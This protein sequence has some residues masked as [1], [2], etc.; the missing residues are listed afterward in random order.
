M[1]IITV[2]F[3]IFFFTAK[4]FGQNDTII[5]A[6]D[7][8]YPPFSFIDKT[9]KPAGYDIE[10]ANEIA[11]I[12]GLKIKISLVNWD[13]ALINLE[14]GKVDVI[15][16]LAYSSS[17]QKKV[18]FSF[19]L[20]TEFYTIF[21]KKKS[22]I[23][24]PGDL[25]NKI[26]AI[27][28]NDI[29]IELFYEPM[30]LKN[31]G[32]IVKSMPE[33]FS[34]INSDSCD[35]AIVP[36][37]LGAQVIED[38]NLDN[39]ESKGE[40]F[41]PSVFC[42]A[43]K[44]DNYEVLAFLNQ[45]IAIMSRD[46]ELDRIYNKWV[47]Y[48]QKEDRY[49]IFFYYALIGLSIFAAIIVLLFLFGYSLKKQVRKKTAEIQK[50]EEFYRVI[51]NAVD[52]GLIILDDSQNIIEANLRAY[53]F[54]SYKNGNLTGKYAGELVRD[55]YIDKVKDLENYVKA[56]KSFFKENVDRK[57]QGKTQNLSVE[58]F[59][60]DITEKK[61]F[62]LVIRDTTKE[63]ENYLK[64]N[65]AK[66]NADKA[67]NAKST[68]LSTI[69]HEIRTPLFA[70]I[71][72]SELMDATELSVKQNEYNK[73][74]KISGKLLLNLVNDILDL[75]KM[76]AEKLE[77]NHGTFG[78]C[79]L[80]EE[81]CEIE[82]AKASEKNINLKVNIDK[83]V[84]LFLVGDHIHIS[85]ILLN[86]LN[87]AIKFTDIGEVSLKVNVENLTEL[88]EYKKINV[89]FSVKDTGIGISPDAQQ[90]LFEPFEQIQNTRERKFGG[91]GLGLA[92]SKQLVNLMG[93]IIE[94]ESTPGKGSIFNVILPLEI[95]STKEIITEERQVEIAENEEITVLLVEDNEFN[96]E[97]LHEQLTQAGFKVSHVYSGFEALEILKTKHFQ[98]ILMDIEMPGMDGFATLAKIRELKLTETP[99]VALSAHNLISDK[100]KALQAGMCDYLHKPITIRELSKTIYKYKAN[101]K[102]LPDTGQKHIDI[103]NGLSLFEYDMERYK[104][105]MVR[106]KK[107]FSD[108]PEKLAGLFKT[109]L[110]QLIDL[111]HNLK[112]AARTIG[113]NVLSELAS[114]NESVLRENPAF[115]KIKYLENL[116]D[117]LKKVIEE[118]DKIIAS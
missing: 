74:I 8:N 83:E 47:K 87:N 101:K 86:L 54:F 18:D 79:E 16:S 97:I 80:V 78:I 60:I 67:N 62:L 34:L 52:D 68:F 118:S 76:E 111:T 84:P 77:L 102:E 94:M 69:S 95:A 112:S 107:H 45:G 28:E 12:T 25:A 71:G 103:K 39:I 55:E 21:A 109:D 75:T 38:E 51:F 48:K 2:S 82:G 17:R 26:P 81:L 59:Q 36:Y 44:H 88:E 56:G 32:V 11:R 37:P 117:E 108:S 5:V 35:Y 116:I 90:K 22:R 14:S 43:V 100:E 15:T 104:R 65:E 46:G 70:I 110:N 93:G 91:T 9:G 64:L 114:E 42:F 53:Q 99:I 85:R 92:I 40:P 98:I 24:G 29:S 19:R 89:V 4:G 73:K 41:L 33:A 10:V 115:F 63:R 106:F 58:G 1:R 72:Y 30:G 50:K 27:L 96:A 66:R 49:K 3:F 20:H 57:F 105:V 61:G 113:A 6:A 31:K 23:N 13:S 7:Y